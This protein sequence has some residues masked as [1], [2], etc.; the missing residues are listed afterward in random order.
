MQLYKQ[1]PQ[2]DMFHHYTIYDQ[3]S[4]D[5]ITLV[6]EIDRS[7]CCNYPYPK[8]EWSWYVDSKKFKGH[9]SVSFKG[10]N[11]GP[12]TVLIELDTD[13]VLNI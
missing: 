2:C 4:N 1:V 3:N 6:I 10:H 13:F 8:N 9:K 5:L 11:N 7:S 12:M